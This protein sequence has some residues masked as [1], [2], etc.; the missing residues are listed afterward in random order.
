MWFRNTRTHTGFTGE[1]VSGATSSDMATVKAELAALR[2]QVCIRYDCT[3]ATHV[4]SVA[5]FPIP[6]AHR[7]RESRNDLLSTQIATL[8]ELL[9][10]AVPS[11]PPSPGRSEA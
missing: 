11:L 7:W 10:T 6:Q 3:P 5:W 1:P 2:A 8:N 9:H 4:F